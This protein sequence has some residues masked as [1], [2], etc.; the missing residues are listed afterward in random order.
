MRSAR[1]RAA[2][3]VAAA[4]VAAAGAAVAA[5][6]AVEVSVAAVKKQTVPVFLDYVGTTEAMRSVTLQAKVS[7]H[8]LEQVAKDGAD[9]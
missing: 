8:L 3:A 6:A 4:G 9:D 5:S 2:S 7:G 1:L